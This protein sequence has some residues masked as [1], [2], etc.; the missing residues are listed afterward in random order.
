MKNILKKRIEEERLFI[1]N[2][3]SKRRRKLIKVNMMIFPGKQ[4]EMNGLRNNSVKTMKT[5]GQSIE[6]NPIKAQ[7]GYLVFKTGSIE[8][9]TNY[10]YHY[11]SVN[12]TKTE[13]T[14]EELLKEADEFNDVIQIRYLVEKLKR[15]INGITI[16]KRSKRGLFNIVGTVYKYLFGTLDQ[17]DKDDMEQK[18]NNLVDTSVQNT[19]L[20][21]IIDV[22]NNGIEIINKLKEKGE[23][24][25]QVNVLIFN[26]QHFTEYVEDIELGMQMTRLGLFNPKLLK[27]DYLKNMNPEKLLRIKTSTWLKT[28]RDRDS[29]ISRF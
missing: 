23:R 19:D 5:I 16:A 11:L 2:Q 14:F 21:M 26:L 6:I 17:D 8:I 22:I 13:Q 10:E 28:D 1:I 15:E 7:N 9:P 25:Q 3:S 12:I 18:I 20:N 27:H 29:Q 24:E 4:K